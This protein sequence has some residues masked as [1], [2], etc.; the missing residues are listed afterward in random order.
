MAKSIAVIGAGIAGLSCAYELQ[1]AGCDVLVFEK[2]PHV[3]GRMASRRKDD[4]IF[5]TGANFF[6]RH[7]RNT[8]GYCKELGLPWKEMTIAPHY[9][10]RNEKLHPLGFNSVWSLLT[11]SSVPFPSRLK[12]IYLFFM[13]GRNMKGLNFFDMS[14]CPPELDS[15]NAYDYVKNLAGKDVADHIVDGFTS[16]YQFHGAKE[17]S[18]TAMASLVSLMVNSTDG[19]RLYHT[20]KMSN[21]PDELARRLQVHTSTPVTRVTAKDNSVLVFSKHGSQSLDAVVCAGT[22]PSTR[23]I[24]TNPT[25]SQRALLDAVKY[26]TTINVSFKIP[27]NILKNIFAVTVPYVENHAI[28]EYTHEA[29]KGHLAHGKTLINVGLHETYAK[30]IISQSDDSIFTLVKKELLKVCPLLKGAAFLLENH[31]LQRW[32]QAM[33][34]FDYRYISDVRAFWDHGQGQ[35]NVYFC[36]D[37]LNTPWVEGSITCG[38]KVA[39]RVLSSI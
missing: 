23:E 8:Y 34:K 35:N 14:T 37:Y 36:G 7:Y 21:I 22:A 19:F 30:Q 4:L 10:F 2:N 33:P 24:Y 18:L 39:Q 16:T 20:N 5:D 17:I 32:P 12:L 26:A 38:K 15:I 27:Q 25:E 11:F 29:M 3:G 1:K 28:S 31:D 6:V 13:I 9:T